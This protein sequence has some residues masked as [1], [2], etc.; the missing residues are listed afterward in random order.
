MD[1]K[2]ATVHTMHACG[3]DIHMTV[4]TG[5]ARRLAAL[6]DKW[7]GTLVMIGEPAEERGAGARAMLADGLYTQFH[8]LIL[9]WA[10]MPMLL[11]QQDK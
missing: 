10:Y 5:T 4:F 11:C 1:D 9:P 3:H 2:G 6:S 7:S 8:C